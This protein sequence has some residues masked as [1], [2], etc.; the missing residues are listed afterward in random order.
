MSEEEHSRAEDGIN[1]VVLDHKTGS[2]ADSV[3]VQVF[4]GE[5]VLMR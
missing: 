5:L 3:T 4:G 1:I 2:V